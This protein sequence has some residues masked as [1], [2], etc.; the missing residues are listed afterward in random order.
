MLDIRTADQE[1]AFQV[2]RW[3]N[4]DYVRS[5][6]LSQEVEDLQRHLEWW[7]NALRSNNKHL[8]MVQFLAT[9][10]GHVRLDFTDHKNSAEISIVMDPAFCGKGFGTEAIK[11]ACRYGFDLYQPEFIEANILTSNKASIRAFEKAGFKFHVSSLT[12]D[13]EPYNNYILE[14]K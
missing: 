9:D 8:L 1:D 2:Y 11:L 4:S 6:R 7:N 14:K 3:R 13:G 12:K 10:V 5:T